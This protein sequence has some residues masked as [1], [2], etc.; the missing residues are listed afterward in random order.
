MAKFGKNVERMEDEF[1]DILQDFRK[2]AFSAED[3]E[4][5][6]HAE[7]EKGLYTLE[8]NEQLRIKLE[9]L[10]VQ[11]TE[12]F[13]SL[14]KGEAS[15]GAAIPQQA[16]HCLES[17]VTVL[18]DAMTTLDDMTAV[19]AASH[20]QVKSALVAVA[21]SKLG[22]H[23]EKGHFSK[24]LEEI[25]QREEGG[26]IDDGQRSI[27]AAVRALSAAPEELN[28]QKIKGR[29]LIRVLSG[30]DSVYEDEDMSATSSNDKV[31]RRRAST[32][33]RE[34]SNLRMTYEQVKFS[35]LA[36]KK[37]ACKSGRV[38]S[39][40]VMSDHLQSFEQT[41]EDGKEAKD[42]SM[43][44]PSRHAKIH[45]KQSKRVQKVVNE[46]GDLAIPIELISV[47]I[48][49]DE[50]F[51]NTRNDV[52][53]ISAITAALEQ[54]NQRLIE[55]LQQSEVLVARKE[56]ELS[57]TNT[58]CM[59]MKV[60]LQELE[61]TLEDTRRGMER[62]VA[63][64]IRSHVLSAIEC[65]LNS[66]PLRQMGLP[67]PTLAASGFGLYRIISRI[68]SYLPPVAASLSAITNVV[69]LKGTKV[70]SQDHM[71]D[72]GHRRAS[73][74]S[75][76]V[77]RA[78]VSTKK[79]QQTGVPA[80]PVG[81][82]I[83]SARRAGPDS[84]CVPRAAVQLSNISAAN[85]TADGQSSS[86]VDRRAERYAR[87]SSTGSSAKPP[88][89]E[90][91]PVSSE[92]RMRSPVILV[93]VSEKEDDELKSGILFLDSPSLS[94]VTSDASHRLK[95]TPSSR[96]PGTS[97]RTNKPTRQRNETAG[98]QAGPAPLKLVVDRSS[99]N[100]TLGSADSSMD[101]ISIQSI[102]TKNK[103]TDTADLER[104]Y[105]SRISTS[106]H[107]VESAAKYENFLASVASSSSPLLLLYDT[108]Q[109]RL[110]D[111]A[112][113]RLLAA[114]SLA[115]S[116]DNYSTFAKLF[117]SVAEEIDRLQAHATALTSSVRATDSMLNN[118]IVLTGYGGGG[119]SPSNRIIDSKVLATVE[120]HM[121]KVGL[122]SGSLTLLQLQLAEY[123]QVFEHIIASEIGRLP[124]LTK[125]NPDFGNSYKQFLECQHTLSE[126][127]KGVLELQSRSKKD[128]LGPIAGSYEQRPPMV[129]T[130][131]LAVEVARYVTRI[132][133]LEAAQDDLTDQVEEAKEEIN[134]LRQQL[135]EEEQK[136][137]RT[138]SALVFFAAQHDDATVPN[139]QQ[140]I[141]Q[142]SKM[143]LSIEGSEA[144][145]FPTLRKRLTVCVQ[146]VPA[147][148]TF[149]TRYSA[150]LA[151][152]NSDRLKI[153]LSRKQRGEDITD[154]ALVCPLCQ[155]DP[156]SG[157]GA[158]PVLTSSPKVVSNLAGGAFG[159]RPNSVSV[160]G[161][162][163][164][165]GFPRLGGSSSG[166]SNSNHTGNG[167][168][169]GPG[170]A[171]TAPAPG[172]SSVSIPSHRFEPPST[173][174]IKGKTS[175][176]RG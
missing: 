87:D 14:K 138:P 94:S 8:S 113:A 53:N 111:F 62:K 46:D 144:M 175:N 157:S 109:D 159:V 23:E 32:I 133:S 95:D 91:A 100:R 15:G 130:S 54:Q 139:M 137:D 140:I 127:S 169:V 79:T 50:T 135:F 10:F 142:L 166:P 104:H 114:T 77:E 55:R 48:M 45:R 110:P 7:E 141:L 37:I 149:I 57:V 107:K 103:G 93:E 51:K 131:A 9:K 101:T 30:G 2:G 106:Q 105:E 22:D 44:S 171:A 60:D 40:H 69:L 155:L 102:S 33:V 156:R 146:C 64:T 124:K 172:R 61:K 115:L 92:N 112:R 108:L 59:R 56:I 11:V 42:E 153:L 98:R 148:E 151:K 161:F 176:S 118:L 132:E 27:D 122:C 96:L 84:S 126:L 5:L 134:W 52:D 17:M 99:S 41:H 83:A 160:Q 26:A 150:M 1:K 164:I 20:L 68:A 162:S 145:D 147:L 125:E 143:R 174:P 70:V 19:T 28:I 39:M 25:K 24:I 82:S 123:R 21:V 158:A 4:Q 71:F 168:G 16:S 117:V 163:G 74:S 89:A 6:L 90:G 75:P 81:S 72:D 121:T 49:T 34:K 58:E 12:L 36:T 43:K 38:A 66:E 73:W 35:K 65:H 119:T 173:S 170:R 78:G 29:K 120:H 129:D 97:G 80:S 67:P 86:S 13:E 116:S 152:W 136:K 128:L 88:Y 31:D 47:E 167:R 63:A 165:N 85:P 154:K 18:D 76:G 3:L